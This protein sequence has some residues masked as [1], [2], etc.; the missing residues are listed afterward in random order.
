MCTSNSH[1]TLAELLPGSI[2]DLEKIRTDYN[3]IR[4]CLLSSNQKLAPRSAAI[5]LGRSVA[6]LISLTQASITS[7]RQ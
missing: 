7:A 2:G 4:P 5:Y 1:A 3:F 6:R